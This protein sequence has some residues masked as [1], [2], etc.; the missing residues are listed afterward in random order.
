M[1]ERNVKLAPSPP[2]LSPTQRWGGT[3]GS[4]VLSPSPRARPPPSRC[5]RRD[6]ASGH[7]STSACGSPPLL[8]RRLASRV[9][10]SALYPRPSKLEA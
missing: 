2:N 10:R 5:S 7:T 4:R 9:R 1:L 8:K 3:Y 6:T